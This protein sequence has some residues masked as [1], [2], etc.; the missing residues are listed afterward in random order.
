MSEDCEEKTSWRERIVNVLAVLVLL[1]AGI[2]WPAA[3][4][5]T[6]EGIDP[7]SLR[8]GSL[9]L[10]PGAEGTTV[11]AVRQST[12]MHAQVTGNVAR[13]RVTQV[14]ENS[15]DEW[16]EGLYVFPLPAGS[17]VDELDM[18]VGER[19]IRGE[20]KRKEE[21]RAIYTQAR[22]EGRRASLVEQE[23][24]NMFTTSVANI[25]PRSWDRGSRTGA[26]PRQ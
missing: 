22:S 12:R 15:T 1:S 23:R 18:L 13:V 4:A 2:V 16:M 19:R 20:I 24:P 8:A 14:F 6:R 11:E 21:A 5:D 17:A 10:K 3:F 25:A 7:A 26:P 9:L